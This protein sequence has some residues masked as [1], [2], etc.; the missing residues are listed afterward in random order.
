MGFE[1][2][3]IDPIAPRFITIAQHQAVY[4]HMIGLEAPKEDA[5]TERSKLVKNPDLGVKKIWY[6]NTIILEQADSKSLKT[7]EQVTLMNWGNA[8]VRDRTIEENECVSGTI[9][10]LHLEDDFKKTKKKLT[11]LAVIDKN[12]VHI[13]LYEFGLLIS[14]DK[15]EKDDELESILT[16]ATEFKT[17]AYVDCNVV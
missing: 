17:P 13:T 6:K 10:E 7:G 11:W 12:I 14:K 9:F 8:I 5:M 2:R 1:Q 4:C 16:T 3:Y 15:L